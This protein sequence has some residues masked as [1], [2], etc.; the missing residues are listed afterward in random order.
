MKIKFQVADVKKP[1]MAVR[2]IVENG[3]RVVFSERGSY[4]I[5]D[6]VGDKLKL[7][8]NGRGSYLMDVEFVGG[9]KGEITVDSG[10]EESV[11]PKDWGGQFRIQEV[12]RKQ[13]FRAANGQQI[14]HYGE[15]AVYVTSECF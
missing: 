12:V 5:N 14:H 9:G 8:E 1:L 7:R 3:N 13:K 4:I 2:R 6:K 10:A 15:R 11:C